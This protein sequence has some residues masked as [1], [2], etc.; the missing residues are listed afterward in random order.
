MHEKHLGSLWKNT[1]I[2]PSIS[3][4]A[5]PVE[6]GV[7]FEAVETVEHE[8]LVVIVVRDELVQ[9]VVIIAEIHHVDVGV[10]GRQVRREAVGVAV[11]DDENPPVPSP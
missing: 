4:C 7:A 9:P 11:L 6:I 2:I 5:G 3:R 8:E 1:A 10:V